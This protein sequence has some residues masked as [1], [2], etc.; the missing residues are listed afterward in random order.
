M[1]LEFIEEDTAQLSTLCK[2]CFRKT[3]RLPTSSRL[4]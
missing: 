3:W 4:C 2:P 1:V